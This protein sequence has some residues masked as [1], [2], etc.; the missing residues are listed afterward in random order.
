MS[1][2]ILGYAI[3]FGST[4]SLIAEVRESGVEV[5]TLSHGHPGEGMDCCMP[6]VVYFDKHED[7]RAGEDAIEQY[8][9]VGS[10]TTHCA[11]CSIACDERPDDR[12]KRRKGD[13]LPQDHE[14][15]DAR[16]AYG[17][18]EYLAHTDYHGTYSW[19]RQFDLAEMVGWV[20]RALRMAVTNELGDISVPLAI[21]VPV[22]F[23]GETLATREEA[24]A[25][26][27]DAAA[28]ASFAQTAFLEEP[29]AALVA[30]LVAREDREARPDGACIAVDFGGGTFDVAVSV[31]GT[32]PWA[33]DVTRGVA[34]GGEH[35]DSLI[36]TKVVA[37]AIGLDGDLTRLPWL[38]TRSSMIMAAGRAASRR[39]LA[40][41]ARRSEG[42]Q[43]ISRIFDRGQVYDFWRAV[44]AAKVALSTQES[45][46]V[47][48]Y[49]PGVQISVPIDRTT[50]ERLA[51]EPMSQVRMTIEDALNASG[52]QPQA[53]ARVVKTGGSSALP[54]FDSLLRDLFPNA[55]FEQKP[56]LTTIVKGLG[57]YVRLQ[58]AAS[59]VSA[60]LPDVLSAATP[61]V[62]PESESDVELTFEPTQMTLDGAGV[63]EAPSQAR[64]HADSEAGPGQSARGSLL[65]RLKRLLGMESD[66]QRERNSDGGS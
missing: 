36:F 32:S 33:A 61:T 52:L 37:P 9:Y 42:C 6:S 11:A 45:T 15:S 44:E 4:N 40:E 30:D 27:R 57:H 28:Q 23:D 49:R 21:G 60:P 54:C 38:R 18:K 3:D 10:G 63:P 66:S 58:S 51:A 35:L 48:F 16:L 14:C 39:Q 59:A 56:T 31:G 7:Y 25:R 62:V 20:I 43:L 50:F 12:A 1:D 26:L 17:L 53:V 65:G 41:A 13:P 64:F 22:V 55:E 46:T 5:A 34:V 8:V 47:D 2:R 19:G 24:I 29:K